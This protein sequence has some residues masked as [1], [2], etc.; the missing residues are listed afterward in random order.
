MSKHAVRTSEAPAPAATYSQGLR[1]GDLVQVAGQ[2]PADPTTGQ[3][4]AGGIAEQTRRTLRNVDAVL[5]AAGATFSDVVMV[6]AYLAR[7]EDFAGFDAAYSDFVSEPYPARTTV[8]VGL[9]EGMLVEVD[10]LAVLPTATGGR[11]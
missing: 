1:T 9:P 2:G 5:S 4:V 11:S 6:R 10:V 7:G 8:Y 3:F